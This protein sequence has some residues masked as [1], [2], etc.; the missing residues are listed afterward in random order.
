MG[1]QYQFLE[2]IVG[3]RIVIASVQRDR[4]GLAAQLRPVLQLAREYLRQLV[5][6][7]RAERIARVQDDRQ[8]I[9]GNDLFGIPALQVAQGRQGAGFTGLDRPRGGGQVGA[10]VLQ[11]GEAGAGAVGGD[12]DG[13]AA[14][15]AA[16]AYDLLF[17][18]GGAGFDA[19]CAQA[20]FFEQAP[21]QCRAKGGTDGVGTLDTQG[22]A[23]VGR[24]RQ[25]SKYWPGQ[26][27]AD[28]TEQQ[29]GA[30]NA[31]DWLITSRQGA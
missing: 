16:G 22:A 15:V 19:D 14:T 5:D 31:P 3:A 4:S 28:E 25:G 12:V 8:A 2:G 18:V 13:H 7:Q 23:V 11:G 29:A 17:V 30:G 21:D 27:I 9:D 6:A 24:D 1:S 26:G 10:A 20:L